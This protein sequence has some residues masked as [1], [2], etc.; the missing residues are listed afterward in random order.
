MQLTISNEQNNQLIS[1][2]VSSSMNF[3]DFKA[4]LN[5]ESDIEPSDQ[6]IILNSKTLTGDANSLEQLGVKNDD[7]LILKKKSASAP[8]TAPSSSSTAPQFG[9]DQQIEMMRQQLLNTPSL[10]SQFFQSNPSAEAILND[11][12]AFK[13][14]MQQS[15][16]QFQ[17]GNGLSAA[18]QAELSRLEQDPDNP[19]NQE[20]ILKL[21]RQEQVEKNLQLAYDITPEAFT[22]VSML[23]IK[24]KV[25]GQP[26]Q[27]FVDSGAQQTI[28]SPRLAERV[29]IDRL[30]DQRF[31]GE[32]RG[33]GSTQ[34]LGKIHSVPIRIGDSDVDIPCSFIV[35]D[36]HVDLLFGL[37]MLKRHHCII[38]LGSNKLRVGSHIETSFLPDN[39]IEENDLLGSSVGNRGQK[40]GFGGNIFSDAV[41]VPAGASS[42]INAPPKKTPAS[43]AAAEAAS[44]RQNTGPK[45]KDE[46]IQ[47]LMGL[48]FSRQEAVKALE[49]AGGNVEVA[50]A[51]L[52]S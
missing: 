52:F 11:P 48:G 38:D 50:A 14:A 41:P 26:V 25:N 13:Q 17:N 18:D 40:L 23:Y 3:E 39:E 24:I 9:N 36:T 19:E 43:S 32:A 20:R 16:E 31:R 46:D 30:I 45:I 33:V 2:D 47:Q 29:G 28:I 49:A 7:F 21:I 44:K 37:D 42:S 27:A 10:R 12:Q 34:I 15:L 6:I 5:A 4:Y 8:S 51:S 35:L 22:S 1:V